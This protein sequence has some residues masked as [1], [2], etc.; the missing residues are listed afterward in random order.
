[1]VLETRNGSHHAASCSA[2]WMLSQEQHH[3]LCVP[4]TPCPCIYTHATAS[5]WSCTTTFIRSCP[6]VTQLSILMYP[7]DCQ[8]LHSAA[9]S[10]TVVPLTMHFVTLLLYRAVLLLH[11]PRAPCNCAVV[12][13]T[14]H[15]NA[16]A[17]PCSTIPSRAGPN[18]T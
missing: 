10:C 3:V 11:C 4:E 7:L 16:A 12:P 17:A 1:M 2:V 13:L 5:S 18:I 8:S 9:F 6:N 14:V 15:C